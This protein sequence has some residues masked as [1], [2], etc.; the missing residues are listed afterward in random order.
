MRVTFNLSR[1]FLQPSVLEEMTKDVTDVQNTTFTLL[2]NMSCDRYRFCIAGR[3][4]VGQGED[5]CTV[6]S[7]PYIPSIDRI[8]YS[9][10][11]RN[12]NFALTVMIMVST[13]ILI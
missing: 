9:L 1:T 12:G 7:L 11:K 3:N 13:Y 4:M 2:G 8:Q 5:S 6:G 10:S